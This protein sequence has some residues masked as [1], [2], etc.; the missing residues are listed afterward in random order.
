MND[1]GKVPSYCIGKKIIA[2]L[3]VQEDDGYIR[4]RRRVKVVDGYALATHKGVTRRIR[5]GEDITP[6]GQDELVFTAWVYF[7]VGDDL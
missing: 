3:N 4:V 5:L 1:D 2:H 7:P 6:P